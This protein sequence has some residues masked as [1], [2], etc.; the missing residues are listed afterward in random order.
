MALM[1]IRTYPD[2]VLREECTPVTEFGEALRELVMDMAET[3]YSNDGVGLAA[4]QVG[5]SKNLIVL[6][7]ASG[8][9]RGKQ[10][11]ALANPKIV[12]K[13]GAIEWDEGCLSLPEVSVRMERHGRVKVRAQDVDGNEFEV[14]GTDLLAVALQ[15]EIDHLTG[16]LLID[17][18]PT[19][20]RR[21]VLRDLTRLKHE[22]EA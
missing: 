3:M 20:R 19:L 12:E 18:I 6:D 5:L 22:G 14:E 9:E 10:F 8:D 16:T 21:M 7:V 15:H 13:E 11:L 2:D 4:P 1:E 17:Y